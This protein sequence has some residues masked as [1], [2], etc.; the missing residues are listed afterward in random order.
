MK[1]LKRPAIKR[2]DEEYR[3]TS[4]DG[5]GVHHYLSGGGQECKCPACD[6]VKLLDWIYYLEEERRLKASEKWPNE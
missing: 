2:M 6:V 4:E 1:R 5:E 3:P